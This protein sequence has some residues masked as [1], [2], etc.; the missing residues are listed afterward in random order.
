MD[1]TESAQVRLLRAAGVR[2]TAMLSRLKDH[3][4]DHISYVIAHNPGRP[5]L[6]VTKLVNGDWSAYEPQPK[7][8]SDMAEQEG[9]TC[10]IC[11]GDWDLCHGIHGPARAWEG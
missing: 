6:I 5:G 8:F 4:I 7:I 10:P 2:S 11:H 9:F 3:S 1:Q